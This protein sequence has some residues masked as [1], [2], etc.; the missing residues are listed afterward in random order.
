[1]EIYVNITYISIFSLYEKSS[2]NDG[3]NTI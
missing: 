3:F 1:M 2:L